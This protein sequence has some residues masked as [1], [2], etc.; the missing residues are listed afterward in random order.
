MQFK[1]VVIQ[2][3]AAVD[4]PVVMTSSEIGERLR[5]A[6]DRLGIRQGLIEE[7]TGIETRRFW[8]NGTQPSDGATLAAEKP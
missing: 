8:N 7:I 4:A 1:N 6:M 3:L 2:S 5:P